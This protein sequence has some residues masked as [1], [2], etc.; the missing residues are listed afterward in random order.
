MKLLANKKFDYITRHYEG[1]EGAPISEWESFESVA[2]MAEFVE[3]YEELGGKLIEHYGG[4]PK[5]AKTALELYH[6]EH[7]SL[8]DYALWPGIRKA[9][10]C[11]N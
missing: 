3:E 4:E 8:E 1:F 2:E 7:K 9:R 10:L 11:S 6:G 5:D